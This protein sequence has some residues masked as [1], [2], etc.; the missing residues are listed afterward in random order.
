MKVLDLDMDYFMDCMVHRYN[1]TKGERL[2]ENMYSKY[3]WDKK[4]VTRF[5]EN[6]LGLSKDKKI[7]GKIIT[8]HNEALDYWKELIGQK[9]LKDP[10]EVIHVDSHADLGL[11]YRS[12]VSIMKE[13]LSYPLLERPKHS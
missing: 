5:F 1:V 10:F 2:C 11:G 6:N 7:K 9:E 3:V 13:L 4:R 8:H 12:W